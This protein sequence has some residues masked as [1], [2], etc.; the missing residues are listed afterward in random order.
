M[1]DVKNYILLVDNYRR[2]ERC[3]NTQG[4]Y[5]VGA[6]TPDEAVELLRKAIKFG[7]I[8]VYYCVDDLE[9]IYLAP[10]TLEG[11]RSRVGYKEV[12]KEIFCDGRYEQRPVK[13]AIDPILNQS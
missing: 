7:S 9:P 8:Q 4:R 5:R 12:V 1:K 2:P 13:S 6:K 3:R 11:N 10:G